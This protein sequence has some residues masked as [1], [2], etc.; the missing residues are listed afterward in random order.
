[1]QIDSAT[2]E[3]VASIAIYE[4]NNEVTPAPPSSKNKQKSNS[5]TFCSNCPST[6]INGSS[7]TTPPLSSSPPPPNSHTTSTKLKTY[8]STSTK[9]TPSSGTGS[10]KT[11]ASYA[12]MVRNSKPT[13]ST[14]SASS[15]ARASK[16]SYEE[17]T[18]TA[19]SSSG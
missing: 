14:P 4:T 16:K 18:R 17:I 19:W 15:S 11:A 8:P 7:K 1:M 2:L 13:A 10:P 5:K 9:S 12:T 3:K 6:P